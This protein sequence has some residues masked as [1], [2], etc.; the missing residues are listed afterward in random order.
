MIPDKVMKP[1][2]QSFEAARMARAARLQQTFA[3]NAAEPQPCE[4]PEINL[5]QLARLTDAT[6]ICKHATLSEPDFSGGY[7]TDDNAGAFILTVLLEELE[8]LSQG[9]WNPASRFI[10]LKGRWLAVYHYVRSFFFTEEIK[11]NR[12]E[13]KSAADIDNMML[14]GQQC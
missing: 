9:G 13:N 6:G 10:R 8:E 14:A 11:T 1:Y 12:G 5:A 4:L 3:T 2:V 7:G